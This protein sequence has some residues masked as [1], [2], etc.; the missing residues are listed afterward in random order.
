MV[1]KVASV[2]I[3]EVQHV[4]SAVQPSVAATAEASRCKVA[5]TWNAGKV[6]AIPHQQLVPLPSG[7]GSGVWTAAQL[8]N[9]TLSSCKTVCLL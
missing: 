5:C 7:S 8:T 9:T 1:V 2:R 6:R 4:V 3:G